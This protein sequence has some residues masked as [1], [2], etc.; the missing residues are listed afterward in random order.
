M[1]YF[2]ISNFSISPLKELSGRVTAV[3]RENIV[4]TSTVTLLRTQEAPSPS[5]R[6]GDA[7]FFRSSRTS[8]PERC[9]LLPVR[10]A[11]CKCEIPPGDLASED[12]GERPLREKILSLYL[13]LPCF[14]HTPAPANA[15]FAVSHFVTH[16]PDLDPTIKEEKGR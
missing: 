12:R 6:R 2:F 16:A 13:A 11:I 9:P 4:C 10:H 15:R 5:R 8:I 14:I 3:R 1:T 7:N